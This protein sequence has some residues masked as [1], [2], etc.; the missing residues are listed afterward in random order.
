MGWGDVVSYP[1]DHVH[2]DASMSPWSVKSHS[3]DAVCQWCG[4]VSY[5]ELESVQ[6]DLV[7][8]PCARTIQEEEMATL[9]TSQ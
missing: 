6:G 3:W 5:D 8:S 7:C 2:Q 1:Y 9:G 4:K